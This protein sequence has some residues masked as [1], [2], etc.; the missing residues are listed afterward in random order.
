MKKRIRIAVIVSL[1]LTAAAFFAPYF[2][3]QNYHNTNELP[4]WIQFICLWIF[5]FMIIFSV[6]S[7]FLAWDNFYESHIHNREYGHDSYGEILHAGDVVSIESVNEKEVTN[8]ESPIFLYR[9]Y[10]TCLHSYKK[11]RN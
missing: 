2:S 10:L 8:C 6:S 3:W 1:I 7:L 11:Y 5:I 4:I 9:G